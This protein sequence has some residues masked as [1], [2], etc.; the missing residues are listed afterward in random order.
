MLDRFKIWVL[1][2]L[3]SAAVLAG[4][5]D[6]TVRSEIPVEEP[7][8]GNVFLSL[9]MNLG[10]NGIGGSRAGESEYGSTTGTPRENAVVSVDLLVFDAESGELVDNFSIGEAQAQKIVNENIIVPIYAEVGKKFN[11]YAAVNMPGTFRNM[12]VV[13]KRITDFSITSAYTDYWDVIN[14]FVPGSYGSQAKLEAGGKGVIPMTGQFVLADGGSKEILISK[15]Y[16]NAG[17]PL[18]IV[19]DVSRIVAKM[20]VLVEKTSPDNPDYAKSIDKVS[21]QQIGWIRMSDVCYLPNG[22]NKSTYIFPQPTGRAEYPLYGDLNMDLDRYIIRGR[23]FGIALDEPMWAKDYVF[24]NGLYLHR[25][26]ISEKRHFAPAEPYNDATLTNTINSY[27]GSDRYTK[28]MYCLE[29]YFSPVSETPDPFATY[30]DVIPMVTHVSIAARL[31]PKSIV[32]LKDYAEKMNEF[33]KEYR[34]NSNFRETYGL[35]DKD[36]TEYDVDQWEIL[37]ETYS[38][39][40]NGDIYRKDYRILQVDSEDDAAHIIKWSL[41]ANKLWSEE[42]TDFENGKYPRGTYYV[43][44]LKYDG[45]HT[46]ADEAVWKQPYLYL[47]AG[48]VAFATGDNSDIKTYS[49]PHLGGWGYYYTY[50]DQTDGTQGGVTPYKAS[51]VTRNTYYVVTVSNFGVPGGTITRPEYIKVNTESIGWDYAGKGDINLH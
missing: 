28:G 51:Q 17:T 36:F 8:S 13:G 50:L 25:D 24:Y 47:T 7:L 23:D 14:E 4:C 33:V 16:M 10:G 9:R 29:N 46:A 42:A 30:D 22:T 41:M 45:E 18:E 2:L 19:A 43:Y 39:Q 11:I 6:D 48:A 3:T 37:K 15:E 44:D 32:I 12:F 40:F 5:S 38:G 20:H 27:D 1:V 34:T 26:N 35:T 21:D 31:V 49:V